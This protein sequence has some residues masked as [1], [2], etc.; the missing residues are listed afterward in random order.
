MIYN[1]EQIHPW[2]HFSGTVV[3]SSLEFFDN[4]LGAPKAIPYT[5]QV[6]RWK[7]A[8]NSLGLLGI[9]ILLVSLTKVLVGQRHLRA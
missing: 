6:W 3:A 7:A 8:F 5:S 2:A 1:P 9:A 4:A